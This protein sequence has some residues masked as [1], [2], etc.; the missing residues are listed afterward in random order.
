MEIAI[1]PV[2]NATERKA[3]V[4]FPFSL[5]KGNAYWVPPMIND[6]IKTLDP[7]TNPA[8]DYCDQEFWLAY[9]NDQVVG[10]IGAIVHH[11]YNEKVGEKLGRINRLEFIEDEAVLQSLLATAED[12]LR[13]RG[14]ERVHGPL[15]LSNL[16]TQG[17]L[18]EGFDHLASIASVYH[19][20]YYG[21]MMEAR[22]YTKERD[23][24]EFRLT[25]GETA[26]KKAQRG[27]EIVKRRYGMEVLTFRN[28]S[29]LEPYIGRVFEILNAAFAELPYTSPLPQELIDFYAGKYL[30]LLNPEF[31]KMIRHENRIIGFQIGMPSLSKAM[32]KAGGKLFP[33]GFYHLRRAQLGK[34]VDTMDIFLTG[35]LPELQSTGAAAAL[36]ASLQESMSEK[37]MQYI[38]TTGIFETN[39]NAISNWKNY[40]HI[41]HKR[42]R[43]FTK[44][45]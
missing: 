10:R 17:M 13:E 39:A 44:D 2:T 37:G 23:W 38:E 8:L 25:L 14:M 24:V 34:G 1:R 18:V 11:A 16:D 36:M 5:Y 15:G 4:K 33:F 6:E 43:V 31:V 32:Q 29:E 41:Q 3:F 30:G 19:L 26:L 45:L 21:P 7:A 40:D 35:V 20:P 22:G 9:R 12:W 27:A 42:R 28:R